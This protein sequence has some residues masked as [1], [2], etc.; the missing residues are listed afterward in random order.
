MPRSVRA[1]SID[2]GTLWNA[3]SGE[4]KYPIIDVDVHPRLGMDRVADYL[5][6]VWKRR[7]MEGNYGPGTLGYWNPSGVMRSDTVLDDGSYVEGSPNSL[8]NHYLDVWGI[9]YAVLNSLGTLNIALS[10]EPAYSAALVRATNDVLVH[11]WLQANS[12]LK[13]SLVVAPN[14]PERAAEEIHRLGSREGIVQVLM[15]SGARM[16]YGQKY[17]HPIYEAATRYKLPIAIHVG[18]EGVGISGAPTAVGYPS[19]YFEWHTGLP[20]TYIAHIA[21]LVA[22]G[23]FVKFPTLKFVL[24]EGGVCWMPALMMRFDKNWKALRQ[25]VPWLEVPPS[26]ILRK[27]VRLSTQPIEEPTQSGQLHALL[28]TFD[29]GEML[30]FSSD[31]PHWD[32]DTP[33]FARKL[34]PQS[35]WRNI[36]SQNACKLYGFGS[37]EGGGQ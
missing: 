18:T 25:S 19:S 6:D 11:E 35:L 17:Y 9:Q 23:V 15:P 31:F 27:H 36:F 33:D 1:T 24:L 5:P 3:M 12:R 26:E 8:V 34:L 32:G 2:F 10:P 7:F 16:P 22:E 30:M 37:K 21:S 29:A 20:G 28:T 13:G 4:E 14:D